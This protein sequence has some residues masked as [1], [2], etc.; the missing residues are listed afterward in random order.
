MWRSDWFSGIL[1]IICC[2]CC[3]TMRGRCIP[4]S[5]FGQSSKH[6]ILV[7][8]LEQCKDAIAIYHLGCVKERTMPIWWI[9]PFAG[10]DQKLLSINAR[11]RGWWWPPEAP[12]NSTAVQS[13]DLGERGYCWIIFFII[14]IIFQ[15]EEKA[16]Q[17]H[18]GRWW[19]GKRII[20]RKQADTKL[21][22]FSSSS[23]EQG[24]IL[25]IFWRVLED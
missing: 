23:V 18:V 6:W 13:N 3:H 7:C 4:W 14:I 21:K 5:S 12:E 16:K 24:R 8:R 9:Y 20:K 11:C 22:G 1:A 10:E 15:Q 17:L 2:C 25:S 19:Q